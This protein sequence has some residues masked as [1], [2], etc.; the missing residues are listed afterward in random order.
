[1]RLLEGK[2]IIVTG[3]N[4]GIGKKIVEKAAQNGANIWACARTK[5]TE[6]EFEL[7]NIADKYQV[8]IKPVYFNLL[9]VEDIEKGIKS[10]LNEKKNIDV[11][12]NNAGI[13]YKGTLNMTSMERFRETFQVNLFAALEIIQLVSKQM[14]R[15][16]RGSIV[17]V[18]SVSGLENYGGNI[19]YGSSKAALI[20]A[21]KEIS[22]ELVMFGI[23]VNSVSPGT[24]R[25]DMNQVRSEKQMM[26]VLERTGLKRMAEPEEI[27]EAIMFLASD[28]STYIT[29]HNLVVDGGRLN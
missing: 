18:A 20:W 23:R 25:T 7:K 13:A 10:I 11:L 24:V 21:T 16:K 26:S 6:F 14:I 29:G 15:N 3:S 1:M 27:A 12:I 8:W 5:N 2:N 19:S 28:K 17:N 9:N 4:R 22:K